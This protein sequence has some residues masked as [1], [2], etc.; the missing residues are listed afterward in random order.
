[1][2]PSEPRWLPRIPRTKPNQLSPATH[3]AS[4][5]R[6]RRRG[7]ARRQQRAAPDSHRL[8]PGCFCSRLPSF[9]QVSL[10]LPWLAKIGSR[11]SRKTLLEIAPS[12]K[13]GRSN[14]VK[15]DLRLP[16]V[17]VLENCT[18]KFWQSCAENLAGN[19]VTHASLNR[20]ACV[21][22]HTTPQW[23]ILALR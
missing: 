5:R 20:H 11:S 15:P 14:S 23:L 17:V 2:E 3:L 19:L 6:R 1:M 7:Q 9:L 16:V 18:A 22:R 10:L 8:I 4:R 13:V 21:S 12:I